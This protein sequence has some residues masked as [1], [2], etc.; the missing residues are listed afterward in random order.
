MLFPKGRALILVAVSLLMAA[1]V[2][3]QK[4]DAPPTAALTSAQIVEQMQQQNQ[5]RSEGLKH[6][7]AVRHYQVEYKGFGADLDAKMEVEV[8]YEA[9]ADK[10]FRIVSQSGSK[11]LIDKVLKR[12][13]ETEKAA[14]K[15][16]TSTALSAANYRF[17]LVG[18]E[19][20]AGRP[21]YIL[22]VEPLVQSKL[23][24]R[25]KVWVDTADFAVVKIVAEPSQ[26]PSFWIART[27]IRHSYAKTGA[28]WLPEQNRSESKVRV[29]GT[30][31]LTIDYGTYEIVPEPAHLAAGN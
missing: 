6:F 14:A 8:N 17:E 15:D 1:S 30:A 12:L 20:I 26:N 24:Y 2:W 27:Q 5:A 18:S 25:G 31:V 29:G 7:R 10:S 4:P 28:F 22:N 23:L 21:A 3:P 9:P 11:V 16:Q 13:L 19:S